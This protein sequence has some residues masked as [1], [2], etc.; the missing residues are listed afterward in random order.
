LRLIFPRSMKTDSFSLRVRKLE[1]R[2]EEKAGLLI[3]Y[4]RC[5][6]YKTTTLAYSISI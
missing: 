1:K 3:M 6:G 4:D 5:F 2:E